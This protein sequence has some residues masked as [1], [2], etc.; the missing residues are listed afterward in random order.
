MYFGK[1][2]KVNKLL[3][4]VYRFTKDK[5]EMLTIVCGIKDEDIE[6]FTKELSKVKT[7]NMEDMLETFITFR[8]LKKYQNDDI[9]QW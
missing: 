5:M 8:N 6:E 1:R 2:E 9:E 4:E 3:D 7:N